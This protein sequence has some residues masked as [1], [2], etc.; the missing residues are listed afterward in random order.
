MLIA[1]ATLLIAAI[2]LFIGG[3]EK[4]VTLRRVDFKEGSLNEQLSMP[5]MTGIACQKECAPRD[6]RSTSI[7]S[8]KETA[9][10]ST[11]AH[12]TPRSRS[13]GWP[14]AMIQALAAVP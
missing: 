1:A 2:R 5:M 10:S 9:P 13:G 12:S 6:Y 7:R 14:G 11:T 3:P 8:P 4:Q